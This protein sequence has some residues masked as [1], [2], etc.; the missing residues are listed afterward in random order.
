MSE[1][2]PAEPVQPRGDRDPSEGL[3]RRSNASELGNAVPDTGRR[4]ESADQ[5]N[6]DWPSYPAG[7]RLWKASEADPVRHDL[8]E[9]VRQPER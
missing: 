1:S 3:R 8:A 2:Q 4:G 7:R 5:R 9:L 6:G